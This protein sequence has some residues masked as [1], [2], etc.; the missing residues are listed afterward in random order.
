MPGFSLY[1]SAF[2]LAAAQKNIPHTA[3][4]LFQWF[5]RKS[6]Q[7]KSHRIFHAHLKLTWTYCEVLSSKKTKML[8][9]RV[10]DVTVTVRISHTLITDAS[11]ISVLYDFFEPCFF[12]CVC[13]GDDCTVYI[14]RC[15]EFGAQFWIPGFLF[16]KNNTVKKKKIFFTYSTLTIWLFIP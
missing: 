5:L 1:S 3:W 10:T 15:T 9:L 13:G 6:I 11:V 12:L 14:C 2:I 4:G 8:S 16:S 7:E